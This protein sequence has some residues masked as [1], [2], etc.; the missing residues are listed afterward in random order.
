MTIYRF[1]FSLLL[2]FFLV[3]FEPVVPSE[4]FYETAYLGDWP[5]SVT[6]YRFYRQTLRQRRSRQ[7]HQQE[8]ADTELTGFYSLFDICFRPFLTTSTSE[9]TQNNNNNF[10]QIS[11]DRL[12]SDELGYNQ[13]LCEICLEVVDLEDCRC[14]CANRHLLHSKCFMELL[15][16]LNP[17]LHKCP[18][19]RRSLFVHPQEINQLLIRSPP[20]DNNTWDAL[21]GHIYLLKLVKPEQMA[22]VNWNESFYSLVTKGRPDQLNRFLQWELVDINATF[23]NIFPSYCALATLFIGIYL[24]RLEGQRVERLQQN[25]RILL[26]QPKIIL[27]RFDG[28][29]E[30]P[31][32]LIY[33]TIDSNLFNQFLLIIDASPSLNLAAIFRYVCTQPNRKL[34]FNYLLTCKAFDIFEPDEH[35]CSALHIAI[36]CR[37]IEYALALLELPEITTQ[38]L[39]EK[40]RRNGGTPIHFAMTFAQDSIVDKIISFPGINWEERDFSGT[41]IHSLYLRRMSEHY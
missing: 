13:K 23:D 41:A 15:R 6:R 34:F 40:D 5:P 35:N 4:S 24:Y 14:C 12:P 37:I 18:L 1:T 29:A 27:D 10:N 33:H 31:R 30:F 3:A 26:A 19:C 20:E 16:T 17:N 39:L 2:T 21:E 22:A 8:R 28:N 32:H 9:P 36:R 7:F 25:L 38:H 11:S